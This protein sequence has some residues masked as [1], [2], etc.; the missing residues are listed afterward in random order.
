MAR[1]AWSGRTRF[2][3]DYT[4][5]AGEEMKRWEEQKAAGERQREEESNIYNMWSFIGTVLS[6]PLGPIAP[7]IGSTIGNIAKAGIV[8]EDVAIMDPSDVGKW[9]M[10]K[11]RATLEAIN[12]EF[13]TYDTAEFWT[14]IQ[15]IGEAAMF[16]YT[17]G[18]G[19]T[20][21]AEFSPWKWGGQGGQTTAGLIGVDDL[22]SRFFGKDED[23]YGMM[24]PVVVTA[25]DIRQSSI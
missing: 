22:W 23:R 11:N 20:P 9:E 6:L 17:M 16:T 15:D 18:G 14:G 7:V 2:L 12:R 3:A 21:G 1:S 24:D 10:S 19:T 8:D 5:E 25:P 4:R 13:E